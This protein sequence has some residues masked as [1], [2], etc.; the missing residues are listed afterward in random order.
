MFYGSFKKKFEIYIWWNS[1]IRGPFERPIVQTVQ[2]LEPRWN[3]LFPFIYSQHS[4][5]VFMHFYRDR[6]RPTAVEPRGF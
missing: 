6:P 5:P 4:L 1:G 3:E 2:S